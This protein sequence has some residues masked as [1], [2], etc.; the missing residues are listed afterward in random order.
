MEFLCYTTLTKFAMISLNLH[1]NPQLNN[2]MSDTMTPEQR[3]RCMAAVHSKD[4]KPEVLVRKFLFAK[5]LRFR[6]CDRK[7]PGTPD[8]VLPKYKTVIFIDGCFGHGHE[9]CKLSHLPHTRVDFWRNKIDTN[10]LRDRRND[11]DLTNAGWRVIRLWECEIR[12]KASQAEALD[13]L[14]HH[15]IGL[16]AP[17]PYIQPSN[18][19]QIAAEP[20]PS[21][22]AYRLSL[23]SSH[24]SQNG[25]MAL[26]I[27]EQE[28]V[29][30]LGNQAYA[31]PISD[32]R[33]EA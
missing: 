33:E 7:L 5:G 19:L 32:N 14:Y 21:P 20:T 3:S 8:I 11:T 4:T 27:I 30:I 9:G 15:I 10:K 26:T 12:H 16:A 31:I 1:S 29:D 2:D 13:A 28:E 6:V 24:S 17:V 25:D 23:I 18:P 22:K